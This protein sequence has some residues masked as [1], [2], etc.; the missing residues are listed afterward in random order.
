MA[1]E[2]VARRYA[3]A[4]FQLASEQ[5]AAEQVGKELHIV[6]D[7][8]AG[9]ENT[10]RYFLAPVV[11]R[12]DKEELILGAFRGKAHAITVHTLLLLIRK[13]RERL[14]REIVEQYA[15]LEVAARGTEPMSI[16]TAR[17]LPDDDLSQMV[18]RLEYLYGKKF[19]VAVSIDPGLIGGVRI[20]MGDRRIDGS[21]AG[22]L[23]ELSRTLFG[24]TH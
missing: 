24:T 6:D 9:D 12:K 19:K 8:I 7:A 14:L 16:M 1:N 22:R 2:I 20:T 23:D 17:A 4:I 21:I 13:R 18:D 3:Q 11:D 15:K 10:K 5:G